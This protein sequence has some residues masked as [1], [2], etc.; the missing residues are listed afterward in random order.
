M[1]A[2]H[3]MLARSLAIVFSIVLVLAASA[4]ADQLSGV[5]ISVNG[6]QVSVKTK[7]ALVNV[8][9]M[10]TTRVVAKGKT[11]SFAKAGGLLGFPM[12]VDVTHQNGVASKIVVKGVAK[13]K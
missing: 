11:A 1:I 9:A 3:R 7:K 10:P 13:K 4:V 8:K 12:I 5:I 2:A 6:T